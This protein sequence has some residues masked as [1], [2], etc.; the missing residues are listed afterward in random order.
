MT[1]SRR[2]CPGRPAHARS[3][4][5]FPLPAGA[6]MIVTFPATPRSRAATRS[7]RPISLGLARST[8]KGPPLPAPERSFSTQPAYVPATAIDPVRRSPNL[9]NHQDLV[10]AFHLHG[11]DPGRVA[12]AC[13]VPGGRAAAESWK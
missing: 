9:A 3:S 10:T 2:G 13:T 6:E 5:V 4:D 7:P 8:V 12:K 11:G 1:A